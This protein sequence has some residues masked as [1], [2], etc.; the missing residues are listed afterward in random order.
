LALRQELRAANA[1]LNETNAQAQVNSNKDITDSK[2]FRGAKCI[3][4]PRYENQCYWYAENFVDEL[5]KKLNEAN[6]KIELLE[7]KNE[8]LLDTKTDL[9][10]KLAK[11]SGQAPVKTPQGLQ[12][13]QGELSGFW[14]R[15]DD[16]Y[17]ETP[18][19]EEKIRE[20]SMSYDSMQS[21]DPHGYRF[22][23][24]FHDHQLWYESKYVAD[25]KFQ[26]DELKKA[27]ASM[28]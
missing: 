18:V 13:C 6:R 3:I 10:V 1:K 21:V 11:F 12:I 9:G 7:A 24:Y 28:K 5:D 17:K 22:M 2:K 20:V 23:L 14:H 19:S 16:L 27:L 25:L 8:E 26:V 4:G 15:V